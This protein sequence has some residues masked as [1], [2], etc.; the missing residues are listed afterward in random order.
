MKKIGILGG[1]FDPIHNGHLKLASQAL[2][3]NNLD[4]V[5]IMPAKHNPFKADK[6]MVGDE[7]RLNMIKLAIKDKPYLCLLE[8]EI[9]GQ[10]ISYTY[11]TMVSLKEDFVDCQLYF[12]VGLDSFLSL[13]T[14]YKGPELLKNVSFI[15][16]LRP[17]YVSEVLENRVF[18]YRSKYDTEVK[19]VKDLMLNISSTQV[20]KAI[21]DNEDI[22]SLV[23][24]QVERYIKENGLYI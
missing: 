24:E 9:K 1:S 16:S 21:K 5:F 11:D 22:S 7:H 3:E 17:G 12:I 4:F 10:E 15:V 19:V 20:R 6:E 13:E 2:I 18:Y 23:P 8:N 14:W